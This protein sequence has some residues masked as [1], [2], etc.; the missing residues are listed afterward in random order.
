[1][2]ISPF[3]LTTFSKLLDEPSTGL[4]PVNRQK[5]WHLISSYSNQNKSVSITTHMVEEAEVLGDR[6][7]ILS[8]GE[9]QVIGSKQKLKEKYG[10]GYILNLHLMCDSNEHREKAIQFVQDRIHHAAYLARRR[11]VKTLYFYL[12]N[13][14]DVSSIIRVLYGSE[15]SCKGG[16][17]QFSLSQASLEHIYFTF[18]DGMNSAVLET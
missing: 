6:I 13:D 12:P 10:D 7:A 17:D 11:Q 5:V 2:T 8:K 1:M 3:L 15:R 18:C 4:D 9:L 16:I 14:I